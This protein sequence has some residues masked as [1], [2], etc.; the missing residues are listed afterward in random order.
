MSERMTKHFSGGVNLFNAEE[1]KNIHNTDGTW[2]W[3]ICQNKNSD[4]RKKLI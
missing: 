4:S 2:T 1:D 3:K